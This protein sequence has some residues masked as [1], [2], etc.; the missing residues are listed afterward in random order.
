[1]ISEIKKINNDTLKNPS[2]KYSRKNLTMFVSFLICCFIG[3][4]E[5]IV[6]AYCFTLNYKP[7]NNLEI[8]EFTFTAFLVMAGYQ[9]GLTVFNKKNE[10]LEE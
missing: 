6:N 2:G 7:G 4:S 3:V 1:M 10:K 9:T 8:N 5:F